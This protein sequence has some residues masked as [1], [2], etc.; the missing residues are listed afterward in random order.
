MDLREDS[1]LSGIFGHA[2]FRVSSER[3]EDIAAHA[4]SRPCAF[5]FAKVSTEETARV[6]ELGAAGFFVVDVNVTL[7][8]DPG[9]PA[10]PVPGIRVTASRPEH[11]AG[12]LEI[13]ESCFRYSRFHLDPLVPVATAHRIK[14]DWVDNYLRGARGERIWIAELDGRPAGFLA[15]LASGKTRIIDL[16]GVRK[17]IQRRGVG[18]ALVSE[19]IR[20]EGPSA[21]LLQVGTQ[22]ANVPSLRLYENAGFRVE[23]TQYVLHLHVRN[24]S[25][26]VPPSCISDPLT[27]IERS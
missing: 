16:V 3:A 8:R 4:R 9:V 21:D 18:R 22:A 11:R 13:A 25:P 5:Y 19:F 10:G 6:R 14:R 17:D 20:Q 2:V 27:S 7:G 15:V 12:V 24:G 26:V 23:R 1:W